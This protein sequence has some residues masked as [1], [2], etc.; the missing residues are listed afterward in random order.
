MDHKV[1]NCNSA[2]CTAYKVPYLFK[3]KSPLVI[4]F[5]FYGTTE[6]HLSPLRP[7]RLG[8]AF[9]KAP[10]GCAISM[11]LTVVMWLYVIH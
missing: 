8:P 7:G 2:R 10:Y 5:S 6:P 3:R 9:I 4:S 1:F 11:M